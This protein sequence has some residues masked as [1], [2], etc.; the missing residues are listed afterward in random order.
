MKRLEKD[1][2]SSTQRKDR[3]RSFRQYANAHL[4]PTTQATYVGQTECKLLTIL[5]VNTTGYAPNKKAKG[6]VRS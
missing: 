4:Y 3:L 1:E 6:K 2:Q 5:M